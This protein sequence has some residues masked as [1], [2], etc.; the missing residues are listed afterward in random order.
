[1]DKKIL[2]FDTETTGTSPKENGIIQLAALVEI[3]GVIIDQILLEMKPFEG[4]VIEEEALEVHGIS[5]EKIAG[6]MDPQ[7]AYRMLIDFMGKHVSKFDRADK[8]YP[9]GYNVKFDIDFLASFFKKC[10]DKYLGSWINWRYLDPLPVLHW[11][12]YTG[13]ISLP[14]YKLSTVCEHFGITINA[15]D[16]LSDIIASREVAAE[17]KALASK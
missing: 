1:M 12:E 4:D 3:K 8:F 17:V 5:V 16:S 6:F 9:A 15:H 14:N 13:K 2:W 11:L 10:H 7:R